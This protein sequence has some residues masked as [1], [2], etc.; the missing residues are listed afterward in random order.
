MFLPP[1]F[2]LGHWRSGTTYLHNLIVRDDQSARPTLYQVLFPRDVSYDG[3]DCVPAAVC[4]V[5][6][7]ETN[8]QC[9][10]CVSFNLLTKTNSPFSAV[11]VFAIWRP[12]VTG[13]DR[14][15][16]AASE[17]AVAT[18][19]REGRAWPTS[20][21]QSTGQ[22]IQD[23]AA[24]LPTGRDSGQHPLHEPAPVHAVG[25]TADPTPDHRVT[26]R[27]FHRVVRGLAPLDSREGPQAL[28][29]LEDLVARRRR[30]RARSTATRP[31]GPA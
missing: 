13:R 24:L 1:L 23:I 19:R 9:P 22:V 25:P 11:H 20:L 29:H 8:R 21:L 4:D 7:S 5:R 2:I 28:L 6:R 12:G 16:Y 14:W 30:L 31:Q 15:D 3:G 17:L 26:Q 10:L 27:P 18:G